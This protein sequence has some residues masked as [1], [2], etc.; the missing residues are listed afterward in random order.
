MQEG[1]NHSEVVSDKSEIIAD[2][3]PRPLTGESSTFIYKSVFKV[4]D[5]D[6]DMNPYD[7]D[8]L[9]SQGTSSKP[10]IGSEY[11]NA[12]TNVN[13]STLD[14]NKTGH[15]EKVRQVQDGGHDAYEKNGNEINQYA[16]QFPT[17]NVTSGPTNAAV[18]PNDTT[19]SSV[20]PNVKEMVESKIEALSSKMD[21]AMDAKLQK[22]NSEISELKSS[23]GNKVSAVKDDLEAQ[24]TT[25]KSSTYD[26]SKGPAYINAICTTVCLIVLGAKSGLIRNFY[27]L[28]VW[29][30]ISTLQF[31]WINTW[32]T[33]VLLKS[34]FQIQ[35]DVFTQ[36]ELMINV[37]TL[38]QMLICVFLFNDDRYLMFKQ[39]CEDSVLTLYNYGIVISSNIYKLLV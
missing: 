22:L 29:F 35:M 21:A 36:E 7:R 15:E 27:Y 9:N 11:D 26:I 20:D 30:L 38:S 25:P 17:H 13:K 39:F 24:I 5:E 37:N 8:L 28:G 31:W 3:D 33:Q 34:L 12:S 23:Q 10:I 18:P 16:G 19:F 2:V 1:D 4:A 14:A 6:P 32:L